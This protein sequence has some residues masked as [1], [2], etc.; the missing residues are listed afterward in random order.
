MD[1]SHH[2]YVD[3]A[4]MLLVAFV[5]M[6]PRSDDLREDVI[7]PSQFGAIFK[8]AP[9]YELT[10]H[11]DETVTFVSTHQHFSV[12]DTTAITDYLYGPFV[13][14]TLVYGVITVRTNDNVSFSTLF[15][16]TEHLKNNGA[17]IVAWSR[18][19]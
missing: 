11:N 4:L 6:L 9:R 1:F 15:T 10:L 16:L 19:K 18:L 2:S 3:L 5:L 12:S 7:V 17:E 8:C 13:N 14:F